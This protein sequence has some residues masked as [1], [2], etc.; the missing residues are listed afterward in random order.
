MVGLTTAGTAPALRLARQ[1][2]A[3][4]RHTALILGVTWRA[5]AILCAAGALDLLWPWPAA[6]RA[7]V[8]LGALALA[9]VRGWR[10]WQAERR[11]ARA[12]QVARE[13]EARRPEM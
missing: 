6:L 10:A 4:T 13:I 11:L 12:E 3:R 1:W 9:A 2:R 8:F 7:L 5:L